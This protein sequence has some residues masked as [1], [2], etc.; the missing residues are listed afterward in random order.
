MNE[1]LIAHYIN[2]CKYTLMDVSQRFIDFPNETTP[3]K[4]IFTKTMKIA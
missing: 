2:V 3:R 1:S 4:S